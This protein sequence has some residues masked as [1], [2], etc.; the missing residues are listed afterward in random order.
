MTRRAIDQFRPQLTPQR[1]VSS[2]GQPHHPTPPPAPSP[3]PIEDAVGTEQVMSPDRE[4][5]PSDPAEPAPDQPAADSSPAPEI[6]APPSQQ[7]R[8]SYFQQQLGRGARALGAPLIWLGVAAFCG[9]TGYAAFQ[10]LSTIPPVPECDRLWFFSLD[11]DKLFC[12]EQAV[13]SGKPESLQAG[14]QL[15]GEWSKTHHLYP[16]ASRLYQEWSK[17]LMQVAKQKALADDLNGAI[18]LAKAIEAGNPAYREAKNSILE[19][20]KLRD[21][22]KLLSST[23]EAALKVQ[24]WKKAEAEL[25]PR[26]SSISEYQRQQIN[27]LRER[28]LTERMAF[29]QLQ[30]IQ[31]LVQAQPGN[32]ETLGRAI[33]LANQMNPASYMRD[34]A[35]RDRQQWSQDLVTIARQRLAGGDL[36][37]AIAVA[38][39]LPAQLALTPDIQDLIWV[40]RAQQPLPDTHS[41][42][43]LPHLWQQITTLAALQQMQPASPIYPLAQATRSRMEHQV[44]DLTQLSLAQSVAQV[45]SV[46]TLQIAI[47]MA[48][49][50]AL[51]RPHRLAAQTLI[52]DWRQD[53]Q[54]VQDFPDLVKARQLAKAGT[55]KNLQAAIAQASKI[56]LGRALRPTAQAAIF[57]WR[58]QIQ[59][60]E[61]NPTL[62]QARQLAKKQQLPQA[63]QVASK[64]APGRALYPAA[65]DAIQNWTAAIQTAEDRPIL[66]EAKSLATQG[67]L[68]AAIGVAYQIAPDRA[69]YDEAQ[70]AITQWS[71][72]LAATRR[73][74]R[75]G[76]YNSPDAT[77]YRARERSL[78]E[79]ESGLRQ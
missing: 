23:V 37:G 18:Q 8:L 43:T 75:N 64:I 28:L 1:P 41:L 77:D 25:Q 51:G 6:A 48:Q 35:Q 22:D 24:D 15:T 79:D 44:Q 56:P 47:Q 5:S 29:D 33:Q 38:Q 17:Q 61:D 26:S 60:I 57:D 19:W 40:S 76:D 20:E 32:V 3:P 27:R 58:Q 54:R 45:P 55:L 50:I 14:I 71:T 11:S 30:Q 66:D 67:N 36:P 21:R 59:T 7:T 4:E 46:P 9:G 52:A 73:T 13:R 12:A 53:I 68:G 2:Q 10:W 65:Q 34:A 49:T 78:Y 74:R 16:K 63:I 69:L 62:D 72:Q 70:T 39:W 31:T 42:L